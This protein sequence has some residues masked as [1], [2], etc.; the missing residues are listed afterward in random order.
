MS[1]EV[2]WD[3]PGPWRSLGRHEA[4]PERFKETKVRHLPSLGVYSVPAFGSKWYPR[5]MHRR[6]AR[7]YRHHIETYGVPGPLL[8]PGPGLGGRRH[9]QTEGLAHRCRRTGLKRASEGAIRV[10]FE[11][12]PRTGIMAGPKARLPQKTRWS[13]HRQWPIRPLS[14]PVG[15]FRHPPESEQFF[16]PGSKIDGS[17]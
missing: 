3:S 14:E 9:L 8:Q 10:I 16:R 13:P 12:H 6:E 5:H 15:E 11:A 17:G 1:E 4:A 2:T 7:E